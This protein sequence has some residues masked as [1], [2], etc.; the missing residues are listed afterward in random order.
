[1]KNPKTNA[2][3]IVSALVGVLQGVVLPM[4]N[5]AMPTGDQLTSAL[6]LV[7]AAVM[8]FKSK[9]DTPSQTPQP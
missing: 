1:M 9:D 7:M 6:T 8:L 3:A 2:A 5:D 4:L